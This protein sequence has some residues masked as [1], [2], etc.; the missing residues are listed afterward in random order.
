MKYVGYILT[1]NTVYIQGT[2]F[3]H[4]AFLLKSILNNINV[5]L[6]EGISD[7]SQ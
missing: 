6:L 4:I 2:Q 3:S 5:F 1:F 7:S